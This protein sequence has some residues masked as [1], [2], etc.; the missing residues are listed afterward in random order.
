MLEHGLSQSPDLGRHL[1]SF[2]IENT[3]PLARWGHDP[4]EGD[5]L[6][7]FRQRASDFILTH[8]PNL[9]QLTIDIDGKDNLYVNPPEEVQRPASLWSRCVNYEASEGFMMWLMATGDEQP[10]CELHFESRLLFFRALR[11]V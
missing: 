11:D 4:P 3:S 10:L 6:K 1:R 8:T 5:P 9:T 7:R 2:G